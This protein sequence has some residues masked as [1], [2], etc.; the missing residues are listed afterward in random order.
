MVEYVLNKNLQEMEL[1]EGEGTI[2][3][4]P[5][6]ENTH[7]LDDIALD[8]INYFRTGATVE[9]V[10]NQLLEDYEESKE[11]IEEDV[12]EF[13]EMGLKCNILIPVAE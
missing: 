2:L 6:S 7:I 3:Y 4:D 11:K 5:K 8:I 12:R 10:I 1:G 13:V 9:S